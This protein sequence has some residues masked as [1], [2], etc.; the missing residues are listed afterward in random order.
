[1]PTLLMQLLIDPP[2][3]CLFS[4]EGDLCPAASVL[5][6]SQTKL[7]WYVATYVSAALELLG[8]VLSG[9]VLVVLPSLH[10]WPRRTHL[11]PMVSSP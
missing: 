7:K 1:M 5:M 6:V 4:S 10:S 9:A 11:Q 8:A 3:K 2:S